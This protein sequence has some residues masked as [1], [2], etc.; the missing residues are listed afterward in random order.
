MRHVGNE[1]VHVDPQVTERQERGTALGEDP[2]RRW[3]GGVLRRAALHLYEVSFLQNVVLVTLQ[4]RE[5]T[6][7]V[8]HGN[9]GGKGDTCN[10]TSVTPLPCAPR[11]AIQEKE[12]PWRGFLTFHPVGLGRKRPICQ[13]ANL[14]PKSPNGPT[15]A[16]LVH[17][18]NEQNKTQNTWD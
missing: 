11:A 4:R 18:E 9:T 13:L 8:V 6:H 1:P 5:V 7:T 16:G 14:R 15:W 3:P 12:N 17:Y 2:A 10:D